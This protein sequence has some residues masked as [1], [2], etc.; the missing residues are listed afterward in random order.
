MAKA[1]QSELEVSGVGKPIAIWIEKF[2]VHSY[3]VDLSKK[4]TLESL[5]QHFQKAAWNH[6]EYLGVG[7]E[8]LQRENRVWV[9]ARLVLNV[10]R[11]P[12]WGETVTV[13][14]WPRKA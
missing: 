13:Q 9:L 2:R 11:H 5:C 6:A 1:E 7:Y 3:E 8:R 14:T 12:R 4:G 10:E